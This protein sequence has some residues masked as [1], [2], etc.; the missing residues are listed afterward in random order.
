MAK[1]KE[2]KPKTTVKKPKSKGFKIAKTVAL[3]VVIIGLAGIAGYFYRENNNLKKNPVSAEEAQK[4]E[5]QRIIESVSKLYTLPTDE[6]PTIFFV[7]DK[8][9]LSEEYKNQEFFKKAENGDYILIY[10]KG[11]IALLYRPSENRLV[12]V[13]PYTV[14]SSINV[15]LVGP[16]AV[17]V[18]TEKAL[19]D[20]F[21]NE[22][23]VVAKTDAKNANTGIT[24]VDI[25]GKYAEQAKKIAETLKGKV[26]NLPEGEAKPDGAD[27]IIIVG[28]AEQPAPVPTQ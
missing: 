7:S 28:A 6:E 12:D 14:Q 13:R 23:A 26:G 19:K 21:K 1:E 8:E 17:R 3:V 27:L 22:I 4:Q 24:V 20:S 25:S 11:K 10:E 15:A 9:K 5:N 16:E 18:V 2:E